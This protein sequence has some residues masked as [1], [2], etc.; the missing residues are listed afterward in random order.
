SFHVRAPWADATKDR[1]PTHSGGRASIVFRPDVSHGLSTSERRQESS[2][3]ECRQNAENFRTFSNG[4]SERRTSSASEF[5]NSI[6]LTAS[7]SLRDSGR[8]RR[9]E[10]FHELALARDRKLVCR[11]DSRHGM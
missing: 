1:P 8:M 6:Y 9:N 7:R 4:K 2:D 11:M 10:N 3:A 5:G